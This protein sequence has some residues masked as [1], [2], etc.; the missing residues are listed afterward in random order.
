[1]VALIIGISLIGALFSLAQ[2]VLM[3][4]LI[5]QVEAGNLEGWIAWCLVAVVIVAALMSGLQ[6]FLL[7]RT[8]E[9]I[10]LR[11]R[12]NLIRKLLRLPIA[13]FDA[14]RTGDLV[15][16]V[17]SDTTLLR[18]VLTQGLIEAIGGV[19]TFVG[20]IIAMLL[21]DWVLFLITFACVA[22][23]AVVVVLLGSR[24]MRAS[25]AAQ[26]KVGELSSSTERVISAM[27]T[28]R[29]RRAA[30]ARRCRG[31]LRARPRH[32]GDLGDHGAGFVPRAAALARARARRRRGARRG[33]RARDRL[34]HLV[35]HVP[36][37]DDRAAHA[38]LRRDLGR[39]V[40]ARRARP[41]RGDHRP[42]R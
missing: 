7:Q 26:E 31:R 41:H 37:L 27:R 16:R 22:V 28:L 33:G 40:G 8:G 21:L 36:V 39:R 15:S 11:A 20:A 14:R 4:L 9:S 35:H 42:A 25:A 10:V 29:A 1:M 6:H 24:V 5:G 23:S 17:G 12:R 32:R 30:G 38:V 34:A 19:L 13:E 18:A 3:G 2:P